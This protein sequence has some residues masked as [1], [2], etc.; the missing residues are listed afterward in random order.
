LAATAFGVSLYEGIV[1]IVGLTILGGVAL[2]RPAEIVWYEWRALKRLRLL[3]ALE[4]LR[5][6]IAVW[7]ESSTSVDDDGGVHRP[8]PS[9]SVNGAVA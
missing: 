7:D 1:A 2:W 6:D 3:E 8:S 9:T 5:V 4:H